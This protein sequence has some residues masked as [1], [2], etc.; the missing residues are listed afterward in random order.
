MMLAADD[1]ST[2]PNGLEFVTIQEGEGAKPK[3]DWEVDVQYTGWLEDGCIFDSS[4][5]TFGADGVP[6]QRGDTGLAD[7]DYADEGW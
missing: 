2:D 4:Y 5:T 6:G 1:L 7:G 3:L